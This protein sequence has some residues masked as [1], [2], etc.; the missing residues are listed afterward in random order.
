MPALTE[1]QAAVYAEV[2]EALDEEGYG[3][4]LNG[5]PVDVRDALAQMELDAVQMHTR[6]L[7]LK[8]LLDAADAEVVPGADDD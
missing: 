6:A 4:L 2:S 3:D 1:L 7:R 5:Q 8:S